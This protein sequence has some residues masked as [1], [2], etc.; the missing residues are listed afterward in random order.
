MTV[1]PPSDRLS[2][3]G[4]LSLGLV[5]KWPL[6]VLGCEL[7]G[8]RWGVGSG[9]FPLFTFAACVFRAGLGWE[10]YFCYRSAIYNSTLGFSL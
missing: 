7:T 2:K 4:R 10:G 3:G 1:L 9:A 5:A 6:Q 8:W